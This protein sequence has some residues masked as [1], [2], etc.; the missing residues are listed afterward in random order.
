MWTTTL[1]AHPLPALQWG[2]VV[3]V[4]LVAAVGDVRTSRI[5]NRL[6]LP[7]LATGLGTSFVTCGAAGALDALAACLL[8]GTPYFLL[9]AFAG[10]GAGDAKLMGAI[11]AWLGLVQGAVVLFAVSL[12]GALIAAVHLVGR[13]G[14]VRTLASVRGF[15]RGA[16]ACLF[17]GVALRDASALLPRAEPSARIPY[18]PAIFVGVTLSALVVLAWR[19]V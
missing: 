12:A 11:G 18:G 1:A 5:P 14:A 8:L 6:T 15:A 16:G 13:R 3:G 17:G 2:V 7:L 19:L 4:T 9:F 10:G